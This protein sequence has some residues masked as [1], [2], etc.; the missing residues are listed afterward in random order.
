MMRDKEM[1]KKN[2]VHFSFDDLD[3]WLIKGGIAV[4]KD[5]KIMLE[6]S[7]EERENLK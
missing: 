1:T 6:Y 5:G 7:D 4:I 3:T 2:V